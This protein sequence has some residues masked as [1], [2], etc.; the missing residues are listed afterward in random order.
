MSANRHRKCG[1]REVGFR[2][3]DMTTADERRILN[4][5]LD[6]RHL[7]VAPMPTL[8][9]IAKVKEMR[10]RALRNIK[11]LGSTITEILILI[12][13]LALMAAMIAPAYQ[14]HKDHPKMYQAWCKQTGNPKNLSYEEWNLLQRAYR[15]RG[16]GSE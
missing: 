11:A 6:R 15:E 13:L 4:A 12:G 9:T 2:R 10:E 8:K 7:R 16:G 1:H 3:G 5:A 14:M